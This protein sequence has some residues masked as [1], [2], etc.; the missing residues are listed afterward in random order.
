MIRDAKVIGGD[1]TFIRLDPTYVIFPIHH[2]LLSSVDVPAS[3]MILK[4]AFL[5]VLD[6]EPTPVEDSGLPRGLHCV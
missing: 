6:S 1:L 5:F 4:E 2:L 3:I